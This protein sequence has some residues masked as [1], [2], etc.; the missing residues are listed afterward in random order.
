MKK[1]R[2]GIIGGTGLN[3]PFKNGMKTR[4]GTPYGPS[5]TITIGSFNGRKTVA[6]LPRHG[7]KHTFPPHRINYRANIWALNSLGVE[8]IFATNAVGAIN[9]NYQLGDIV[10]PKDFIDFTRSRISTFYDEAPVTHI[11]VSVP[12]CP[13]LR[14]LLLNATK[15][16][17]VK[18]WDDAVY[19]CAE[20]P[21]YETPAEIRMFRILG[22]D[23]VGMTS[24]PELVL[25]RELEM[26]YASICF[27]T[28]MAA[29]LQN[30][31]SAELIEEY[32]RKL[33]CTLKD[34]LQEAT[35]NVFWKKTCFCSRTLEGTRF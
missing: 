8:R 4:V 13:Q 21:R 26:C 9:I 14:T 25:A 28:N 11:D 33:E 2:I 19:L 35:K 16:K 15:K 7:E 34:I 12:Y 23:I 18:V 1:T 20:G 5:P 22:A 24:L 29:G 17:D 6:Y 30:H 3:T 32:S 31:L 27:I 10:V